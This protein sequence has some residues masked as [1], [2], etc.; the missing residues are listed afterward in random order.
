MAK[1]K[2]YTR[3]I[4]ED[5]TVTVTGDADSGFPESRLYDRDVS[6]YW[7]DT[8]TEAKTFHVDQGASGN[9][10]V[11]FLAIVGHNF[12][13]EDLTWEYSEN[14]VDWTPAVDGWTQGDNLQIVKT[15]PTALTKRYWRV[16]LSS[17][18]N[19]RC[20]EIFMSY[21]Y[22]FQV[23]FNQAQLGL[24]RSNVLW[25]ET[26]GG[27]DRSVKLSSVRRVRNYN[28]FLDEDSESFSRTNF[29]AAMDDL[30]DLSKPF[31]LKDH[32]GSYFMVH[33]TNDPEEAWITEK[34]TP[35]ALEMIEQLAV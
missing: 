14:D 21:G 6:L 13:G 18:A 29:R 34:H 10:S 28:L 26:V 15:L 25:Q 30:S 4:L 22:E 1:I 9:E 17:M 16:T 8:V 11:D 23:D 2:L 19:P 7:K 12:N 5:G 35:L 3:N 20:A 32:E 24:K 31:F 27:V 33:L